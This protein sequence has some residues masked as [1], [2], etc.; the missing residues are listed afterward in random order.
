MTAC[1]GAWRLSGILSVVPPLSPQYNLLPTKTEPN[2]SENVSLVAVG[3]KR[4][5]ESVRA[6]MRKM[7]VGSMLAN[8]RKWCFLCP[9]Q[10]NPTAFKKRSSSATKRTHQ[11]E[12]SCSNSQIDCSTF[13]FVVCDSV[14]VFF[15]NSSIHNMSSRVPASSS[16]LA[17]PTS[18]MHVVN[19]SKHVVPAPSLHIASSMHGTL[20]APPRHGTPAPSIMHFAPAP[21]KH[22]AP[23][24]IAPAPSMH[25][26]PMHTAP[27]PSLHFEPARA[28][29]RHF[30]SAVSPPAHFAPGPA[31]A[32]APASTKH[33]IPAVPSRHFVSAPPTR[34]GPASS[35]HLAAPSMHSQSLHSSSFALRAL[36]AQPHKAPIDSVSSV[37]PFAATAMN[38]DNPMQGD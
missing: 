1:A 27:A 7:M 21:S 6:S 35:L 17:S 24:H 10:T 8:I 13:R 2:Y 38:V 28:P 25:F 30:A 19:S 20:P 5:S 15:V 32:I 31:P 26:A 34:I 11:L 9:N 18:S 22:F 3:N 37:F 4:K 33:T 14:C 29:S 16:S 12:P 23:M 36:R